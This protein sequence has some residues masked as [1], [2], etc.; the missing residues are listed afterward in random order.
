LL[1]LLLII[2]FLFIKEFMYTFLILILDL[3][4]NNKIFN[5]KSRLNI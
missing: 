2:S 5:R 1:M 4:I 3:L